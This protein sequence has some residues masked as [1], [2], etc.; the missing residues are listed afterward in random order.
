MQPVMIK[1]VDAVSDDDWKYD[2]EQLDLE[3]EEIF[4]LGFLINDAPEFVVLA[5]SVGVDGA[6]CSQRLLIPKG[7]IKELRFYPELS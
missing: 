2:G 1:W 6:S 7:W 5:L 4:T 3:P